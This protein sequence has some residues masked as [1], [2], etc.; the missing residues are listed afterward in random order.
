MND[1]IISCPKCGY[2]YLPS[3]IFVP[4]AF[5]GKP[6]FIRRDVDGDIQSYSGKESDYTEIYKCD[7]C[8][9]SFKITATLDFKTEIHA[10]TDFENLHETKL[11]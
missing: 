11:D 6:V 10:P 2:Q 3:E 4:S 9:T 1:K 8:N 5:F 7:N